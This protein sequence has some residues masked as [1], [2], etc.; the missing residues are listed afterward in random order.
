MDGITTDDRRRPL[1]VDARQFGGMHKKRLGG[2]IDPGRDRTAQIFSLFCQRIERRGC[3]KIND[4]GWTPIQIHHCYRVG[5]TVGAYGTR[6]L[7]ADFDAGL[8]TYIHNEWVV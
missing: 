7:V 8:Y 4:A 3:S 6:I 2:E 5:D 1:Q